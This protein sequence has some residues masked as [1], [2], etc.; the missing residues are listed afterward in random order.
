M[1]TVFYD[2]D[3]AAVLRAPSIFLA[4]PTQRSRKSAPMTPW[5][6]KAC[7]LLATFDGDV[8]IPEFRDRDFDVAAP[9]RFGAPASPHASMKATSFNILTWETHGIEHATAVLFW[10]PFSISDDDASLP[11][12]TTRAE[13]SR[14]MVRSPDRIV[15]GMPAQSLSSSHIRFHAHHAG[16]PIHATLEAAV[17]AAHARATR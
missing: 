16:I 3:V 17:A 15:L 6:A 10:M 9:V 12:F 7:E 13:V 4:G 1:R 11:G 8:V 2:D 14:E 5:R